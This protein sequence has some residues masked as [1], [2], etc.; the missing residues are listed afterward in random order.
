MLVGIDGNEANVERRVG[1][2][3]F[4]YELIR[5]FYKLRNRGEVEYVFQIY[6]KNEPL[7][8]MPEANKWFNYKIVKPRPAWTQFALPTYLFLDKN[9]PDVFFSPTHYAPRFSR[10]PR[11]ISVMDIAYL[12]YPETFNKDDLYQLVNWTMYSI[13]KSKKV[14]TISQNSKND[15]ISRYR[16]K[17]DKVEVVYPGIK[18]GSNDMSQEKVREKYNIEGPFILFV[19]TLQPRKNLVRLIEALVKI[20]E[21][22]K[23][24]LVVVGRKGWKYEE[25]LAAPKKYGVEDKVIFLDFVDDH[26]LTELY[27]EAELFVMPSLYEGFGLP[28]LEAMKNGCPVAMSNISSLPEAGGVAAAYFD[29]KSVED[30]ATVITDVLKDKKMQEN[31]RKKGYEQVKK[32]S[33]EKSAR[34]T[35]KILESAVKT[36]TSTN[37]QQ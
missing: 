35:L 31:M 1:V 11:V 36:N 6:L 28:V 4:A 9:K 10:I 32:F 20:E 15:I 19:S 7:K 21:T 30:M 5:H 22:T 16:L 34:E 26:D 17:H 14:I 33:W 27:K 12:L 2:S 18:P 8:H 29:P 24:K 37:N 23:V 13:K 3:E 25:I